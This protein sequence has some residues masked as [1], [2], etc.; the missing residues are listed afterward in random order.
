MSQAIHHLTAAMQHAMENRPEVGG[1][2]HLAE[3]L[4]AAGVT[5][6][7]WTLPSCQSLYLTTQGNVVMQGTPLVSGISEVPSFNQEALIRALRT[8]QAG[9]SSFEQFLSAAWQAGVVTYEVDFNA[10][11]VSYVGVLGECYVEAYPAVALP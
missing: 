5:H 1:F 6:N 2:P 7:R 3:V 10:R 9:Q 11:T 4:R 8:D